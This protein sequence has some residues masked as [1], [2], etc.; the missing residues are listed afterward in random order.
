MSVK[1]PVKWNALQPSRHLTEAGRVNVE[2]AALPDSGGRQ[3]EGPVADSPRIA[4]I[5]NRRSSV[6]RALEWL[7]PR[8]GTKNESPLSEKMGVRLP[9][10]DRHMASKRV[11]KVKTRELDGRMAQKT[12]GDRVL[13]HHAELVRLDEAMSLWSKASAFTDA[14][15]LPGQRINPASLHAFLHR[16]DEELAALESAIHAQKQALAKTL[17]ICTKD[18]AWLR[19]LGRRLDTQRQH[20]QDTR[21]R[22]NAVLQGKGLSTADVQLYVDAGIPITPQT[23]DLAFTDGDFQRGS[24]RPTE[25]GGVHSVEFLKARVTDPV[26]KEVTLVPKVF[27]G[28]PAKVQLP[29]AASATQIKV[30]VL[31]CRA[32][33]ASKVNDALRL[34]LIP[35]TELALLDGQ[36]GV[37][38]DVVPGDPLQRKG[39]A[40]LKVSKEVKAWAEQNHSDLQKFAQAKGF[41]GAEVVDDTIVFS[42][43]TTSMVLDERG[44]Y[45]TVDG[46]P[47]KV[48]APADIQSSPDVL[49]DS[50]RKIAQLAAATCFNFLINS[51]DGHLGNCAFRPDGVLQYFDNDISFGRHSP[52]LDVVL[53]G[54]VRAVHLT[55]LPEVI[56]TS[57]YVAVMAMTPDRLTAQLMGLLPPEEIKA[58]CER[59]AALQRYCAHCAAF[60][61]VLADD[62]PAWG[63]AEVQHELGLDQIIAAR[64]KLDQ[65]EAL[66]GDLARRNVPARY[67]LN[68]CVTEA[69]TQA[70]LRDERPLDPDLA[71]TFDPVALHAD[72][73][74][75]SSPAAVSA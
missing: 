68:L 64:G 19:A 14:A 55:H 26:T 72:L 5:G 1:N 18:R 22:M 70:C 61:K 2:S 21:Q 65:L 12:F 50:P 74:Q 13:P 25:K 41:D 15:A 8:C 43:E 45:K 31:S 20:L 11:L 38:M 39:R 52:D 44:E 27:K 24:A 48:P 23:R 6:K 49:L 16:I 10:F 53:G 4:T 58:T 56:P 30:P 32:V 69:R 51:S 7:K 73:V 33:A 67:L 28:E 42:R 60:R 3:G 59:L 75:L 37:A 35:K 47:F 29:E 9:A 62:S 36:L 63:Q 71:V 40:V 54:G 17:P 57:L 66:E 34:Q 46:K